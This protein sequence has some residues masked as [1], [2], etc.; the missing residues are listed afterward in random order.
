MVDKG[1]SSGSLSSGRLLRSLF[2][3]A[4]LVRGLC[5]WPRDT[6]INWS[7]GGL[8]GETGG[9]TGI[10]CRTSLL[11]DI[12]RLVLLSRVMSWIISH[13]HWLGMRW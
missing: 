9:S 1:K 7:G 10:S 11:L 4:G 8:T 5:A 3:G 12:V 2:S 13:I 6:S